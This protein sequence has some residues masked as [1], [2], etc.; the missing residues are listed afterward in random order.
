MAVRVGW[1]HDLENPTAPGSTGQGKIEGEA[2]AGTHA[3]QEQSGR[4]QG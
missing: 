1:L 2:A 4:A 3:K